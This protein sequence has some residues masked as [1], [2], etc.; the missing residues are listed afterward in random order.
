MFFFL[1]FLVI[2]KDCIGGVMV[3]VLTTNSVDHGFM[4][5]SGQTKDY[6]NGICC[7][8]A[9]NAAL[10]SKSKD[11]FAQNQ[12]NVS[13][14]CDISTC[15][16]ELLWASTIIIQLCWSSTKQI[17]SSSHWLCHVLA[18]IWLKNYSFSINQQSLTHSRTHLYY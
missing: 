7:F 12:D 10:I 1:F 5:R 3:C 6:K 8:A 2:Y 16:S 14:W 13:R 4:P 15:T 11:W 18:M 17:S 9:K